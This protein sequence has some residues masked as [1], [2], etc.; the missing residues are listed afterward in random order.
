MKQIFKWKSFATVII[1]LSIIFALL[2]ISACSSTKLVSRWHDIEYSGPK[3]K[4]VLVIGIMKNDIQRRYFEDELVK[5]IRDNGGQAVTSYTL[6]PDLASIDD[7][8]EMTAI[9]K[10]TGV[11]SVVIT[12]L[13][14]IDKEQR[15]VPAR[16]D[17][18]PTMGGG[19][20]Y[21]YYRSSYQAV[22]QPAYTTTDTIVRME[23]R[24][25]ATSTATMVWAG[26]TESMNPGSTDSVI[27]ETADV[28][29]SDMQENGLI[30]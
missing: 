7:K 8:A 20:Y 4:N 30:R 16:V 5:I 3:L 9:V 27:S 28:I 26:M 24:V 1:R 21:G 19:G 22:Y 2:A 15:T 14:S 12:S 29:R 13:K 11:D 23:T 17:Y 18:I 25:Y 6:I 10:E